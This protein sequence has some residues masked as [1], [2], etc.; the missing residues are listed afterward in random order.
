MQ[1][2]MGKYMVLFRE[3]YHNAN[4]FIFTIESTH[5]NAVLKHY[6]NG[7]T[8]RHIRNWWSSWKYENLMNE[9]LTSGV[10]EPIKYI[11]LLDEKMQRKKR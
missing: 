6:D 11:V 8:C 9:Y 4:P 1:V 7:I 5:V 2:D 3:L 10:I